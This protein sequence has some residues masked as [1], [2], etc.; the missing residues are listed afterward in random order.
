VPPP[1]Q[2][3]GLFPT[4]IVPVPTPVLGVPGL[5][6]LV[7]NAQTGQ[8]LPGATV[9]VAGR[10]ATTDAGGAYVLTGLAAGVV[11]VTATAAGF[12]TDTAS[13]TIPPNGNATQ[14]FGLS[15]TLASGQIRIILTWSNAPR[16]IDAELYLPG[17]GRANAVTAY[18]RSRGG[19]TL[20]VDDRDGAGPETIT[21]SQ[22]IGGQY[23]YVVHQYS[24]DGSLASSGARVRVLRGDAE[25]QAFTVPS[26]APNARWWTVFTLDGASGQ[27][28]PVNQMSSQSPVPR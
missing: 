5:T 3:Q 18:T 24:N 6:G 4:P 9:A 17:G 13:V 2:P 8:P 10:T 1:P 22:P 15:Q 27:I 26:G 16:D 11:P 25:V 19:A 23:T 20:D 21:L 28:T 14:N 7:R 12:I